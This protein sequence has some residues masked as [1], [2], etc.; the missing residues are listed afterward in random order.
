MDSSSR[1]VLAKA[2]Y[3]KA[4]ERSGIST[5]PVRQGERIDGEGYRC[6]LAADEY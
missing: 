6:L 3:E 4:E 1:W 2:W 5:S